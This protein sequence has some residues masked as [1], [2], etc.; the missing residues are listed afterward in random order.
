MYGD[1]IRSFRMIR[2]FTQ[3]YMA[4]QLHVAQNTYSKYENNGEKLSIETLEKIAKALGVSLTDLISNTP[5]IINNQTSN[6]GTQ[7]GNVE[8]LYSDQKELFSKMIGS[9][10]EEIRNLR[11]VISSLKDVITSLSNGK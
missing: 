11:E 9:K 3:E 4:E 2:G 7:V 10:D 5:I 1:K 6:Q 8:N